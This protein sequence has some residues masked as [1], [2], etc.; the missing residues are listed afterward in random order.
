[1]MMHPS[2]RETVALQLRL[3]G[4]ALVGPFE[5]EQ[6]S[7]A[8]VEHEW[9]AVPQYNGEFR[10]DVKARPEFSDLPLSQGH[11]AIGPHTE[12]IALQQSPRFLSLHCVAPATCGGGYTNLYDGYRVLEEMTLAEMALCTS[13][14]FDFLTTGSFD[15]E[16]ANKA[17]RRIVQMAPC[18]D[19]QISFSDNFFRWGDL[20]PTDL[21]TA[22][23]APLSQQTRAVVQK[24]LAACD[25]TEI[26][27][28]IPR[29]ATLV[30][31]NYRML[32]SRDA[33]TDRN[34]HLVRHWME[35]RK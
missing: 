23:A 26:K 3:R 32:H 10:Y 5:S 18:G 4:Y 33:Y 17:S 2:D 13:E 14:T 34:R 7:H 16:A 11:R 6:A 22:Q 8:F 27:I 12:G 1:M 28:L 24:I 15:K 25:S 9:T 30:W 19:V 29:Q 35:S 31:D 21:A 20:N